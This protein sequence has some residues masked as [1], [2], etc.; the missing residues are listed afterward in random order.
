MASS[1]HF[2]C[3]PGRCRQCGGKGHPR[4]Y[5][6][7]SCSASCR[8]R[9]GPSGPATCCRL[10][11]KH[12]V[13]NNGIRSNC[14]HQWSSITEVNEYLPKF[15]HL[16]K[17]RVLPIIPVI[18]QPIFSVNWKRWVTD[19]GSNSLSGTF[20]WVAQTATLFPL[21]ATEVRPPWL[22]ALK[23]YSVGNKTAYLVRFFFQGGVFFIQFSYKI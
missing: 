4:G 9:T 23:A 7:H 22:M 10:Q 3:T 13:N 8:P 16:T 11:H 17:V 2:E 18:T 20:L 5:R 12:H 19:E 14:F 21:S 15:A 1:Q 6:N